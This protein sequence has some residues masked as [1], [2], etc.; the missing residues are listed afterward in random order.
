MEKDDFNTLNP[1][2]LH[3]V[4]WLGEANIFLNKPYE[5]NYGMYLKHFHNVCKIIAYKEPSFVYE[6]DFKSLVGEPWDTDISA[7]KKQDRCIKKVI[8]V[9]N[10]GLME[11][12]I[13]KSQKTL[14]FEDLMDACYHQKFLR[15]RVN[16]ISGSGCAV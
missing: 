12:S 4:Q 7:N 6:V 3:Y 10:I 9:V 15:G 16:K 2:T 5:I 13:N 8:S 11:K 1:L 14:F